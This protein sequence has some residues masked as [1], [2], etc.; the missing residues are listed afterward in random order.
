MLSIYRGS[1]CALFLSALLSTAALHAQD[2]SSAPRHTVD[3][4]SIHPIDRI[5]TA[6]DDQARVIRAGNVHPLARPEYDLGTVAPDLRMER[7]ILVLQP[8]E[9]QQAALEALLAA[10]KDPNSP[11]YHQWLTP[12]EFGSAFG[13]STHDASQ[14]VN[15]LKGHGFEVEPI[16]NSGRSIVFSGTASQVESAF[17]TSIH[18]YSVNGARHYANAADPEIPRALAAVVDGFVS[19]H[20]FHSAPQHTFGERLLKISPNFT[21]GTAHYLS[22]ADFATIYD[23]N[24]LYNNSIDGTGQSIAI[25]G[26]C[27]IKMADVQTFRTEFGLP[28][29][30]P[31]VIVNGSNPGIVNQNEQ[32]EATLDVEWSGAVARKAAI[33]FVVSASSFFTDGISLSSQYIVNHNVAPVMSLSF[34]SCEATI[35]SSQNNFWNSLWQQGAAEGISVFVSAGDS[36]AAGCD[37]A[38]ST[39]AKKGLG[40]NGLCSPPYSTCVGGTEFNDAAN[41]SSYWSSTNTPPTQNSALSYI[42]EMAWNESGTVSGGSQLWATGGGKSTVYNKPSWQS[43]PGV[44]ADGKR[45]VPD[46]SLT[47]ATHDGYLVQMNGNLYIV[48]GTSASSP[49]LAGLMGLVVQKTGSPQGNA[50]P[51]FYSLA[52]KQSTGGAAV[53]H[54][55]ITGN[56]SVPG[57]TGFSAGPGYDQ[58]TGLGSVDAAVMVNNWSGSSS[59]TPDFQLS[60][61][62]SSINVTVGTQN[63]LSVQTTVS[64]GFSASVSLTIG[65]LPNGLTAQFLPNPIAAPGSGNSTLTLTAASNTT[66]GQ[67]NLTISAVGGS[68]TRTAPLAVTVLS[69]CSF[70]LNSSTASPP[71]AGG[72]FNASVI[73][74]AGC[75]WSASSNVNWMSITPPASGTGSGSVT[76]NVQANTGSSRVGTLTIAGQ[77]LT[78]TQAAGAQSVTLTPTSAKYNW[79]GGRGTIN[80]FANVPW[81][82]TSNANWL[83]ITGG[84]SSAN[85]NTVVSYSVTINIGSTRTGTI[86]IAGVPFT[87]TQTGF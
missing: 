78:V 84:S 46:V 63:G 12:E 83:T 68:I 18:S 8:D 48:G 15:W 56:N 6:V 57:L 65:P 55:T 51:N 22:P 47:A 1:N 85:G 17:H 86:T 50:N 76:Y 74:S 2:L 60:A 87:V 67:Y 11:Q 19:L 23:V 25:A 82:A 71:A 59:P 24:P 42:P 49:S 16:E 39:S 26:R 20:D 44:P 10:Q 35:G 3:W 13:V 61:T 58:A 81:T 70:S 32:F 38:S 34:G 30:N 77:T 45:D 33:Q 29:N 40:I 4:K 9:S 27:N 5:V 69:N 43:A 73:T 53:F 21:S 54:D 64:G 37:S 14:V 41:P 80:V 31:T 72:N 52:T 36:G 62:T 7:L 79:G 75:S 28:V 66:P